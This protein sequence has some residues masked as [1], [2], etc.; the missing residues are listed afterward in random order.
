[1]KLW[2]RGPIIACGSSGFALCGCKPHT[3]KPTGQCALIE[4]V[5]SPDR[6]SHNWSVIMNFEV[7]EN[8]Y[9]PHGQHDGIREVA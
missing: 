3:T 5:E 4:L 1:M 6:K 7:E 8:K 2:L 9:A